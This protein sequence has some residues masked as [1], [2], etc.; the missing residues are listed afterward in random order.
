MKDDRSLP[1]RVESG[2]P[3]R[4]SGSLNFDRAAIL[5]LGGTRNLGENA[6]LSV[7]VR[8]V[9]V[10]HRRLFSTYNGG[11][12]TPH[13]LFFDIN[14]GG[15]IGKADRYSIRL[16]YNGVLVGALAERQGLL[17]KASLTPGDWVF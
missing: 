2:K 8:N 14:A 16:N 5:T 6:T 11:S 17:R 7:A 15:F 13:E 1:V 3:I 10:G 4:G 12:T 9:P